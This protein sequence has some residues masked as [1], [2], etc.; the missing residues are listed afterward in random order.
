MQMIYS[1]L[2]WKKW[3]ATTSMDMWNW[4]VLGYNLHP[5]QKENVVTVLS[6]NVC[7]LKSKLL[8]E[9]FCKE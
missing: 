7:G 1:T 3:T 5:R 8:D 2:E 4:P 6:L 9:F